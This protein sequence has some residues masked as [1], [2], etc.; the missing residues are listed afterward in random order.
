MPRVLSDFHKRVTRKNGRGPLPQPRKGLTAVH[1]PV[2][3]RDTIR[4]ARHGPDVPWGCVEK[5]EKNRRPAVAQGSHFNPA[6]FPAPPAR[7]GST[8][9]AFRSAAFLGSFRSPTARLETSSRT[10]DPKAGSALLLQRD[11]IRTARHRPDV[12]WGC[13]EKPEKNRRPQ[14]RRSALPATRCL[15]SLIGSWATDKRGRINRPWLKKRSPFNPPRRAAF[16]VAQ[17]SHFNP[18]AFPAPPGTSG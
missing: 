1:C 8:D 9:L 18:A 11:T 14:R 3:Q 12:P 4:T 10:A 5:P 15:E 6:A 16:P 13:V 17:G 7:Q 2:L